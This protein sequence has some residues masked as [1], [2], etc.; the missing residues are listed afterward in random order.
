MKK[1]MLGMALVAVMV[2][3]TNVY[4]QNPQ[5]KEA[6][7]EQTVTKKKATKAKKACCT[8]KKAETATPAAATSKK[9]SKK[10]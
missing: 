5:K 2:L 9:V 6:K 10:K 8:A 1:I 3:G 7:T 4:A